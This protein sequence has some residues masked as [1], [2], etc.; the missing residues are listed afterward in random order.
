MLFRYKCFEILTVFLVSLVKA[1]PEMSHSRPLLFVS[2]MFIIRRR[3]ALNGAQSQC[4]LQTQFSF[5]GRASD[6]RR[7]VR[8]GFGDRLISSFVYQSNTCGCLG[9]KAG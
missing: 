8:V 3:N 1:G 7:A 6:Q 2:E 9:E 4:R 5:A